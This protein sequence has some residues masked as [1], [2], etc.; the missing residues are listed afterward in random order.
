VFLLVSTGAAE[1]VL[2]LL[3][4]AAGLP[5]PLT[6][7][8]ILW[9]NLVTNGIQDVA[10]AFEPGEGNVLRRP[11]RSPT[12]RIFNRLMIERTLIAALVMGPLAFAVFVWLLESG[13]S[14]TAAR[15]QILLLMVLFEIVNIGNARSETV[16]LFR[17][18]PLRSPILLLGTVSA[19]LIHVGAM[20]LPQIQLVLETEPVS[21]TRWLALLAVAITVAVAIEVHKLLGASRVSE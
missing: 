17:L 13:L 18:S 10:L 2:V 8:Q 6:P 1:V 21:L 3:A 11:P 20:S 19:F 5:L 9:L 14:E 7:V 15:N 16:S 4:L 12:E